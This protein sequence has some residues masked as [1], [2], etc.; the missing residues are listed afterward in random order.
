MLDDLLYAAF[1]LQGFYGRQVRA[2]AC[3][4]GVTKWAVANLHRSINSHDTRRKRVV[5]SQQLC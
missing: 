3:C 4:L 2:S 1:P 5:E